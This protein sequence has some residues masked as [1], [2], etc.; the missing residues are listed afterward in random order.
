VDNVDKIC[1]EIGGRLRTA[2]VEK[3]M[4]QADVA[5]A[6]NIA[7]SQYGKVETGKVIPSLKTLIKAAEVLGTNLNKLVYGSDNFTGV[8]I[9]LKD[10]NLIE[11]VN[12]I[13][14]LS[15]EDRSLAIQLLDLIA[16]KKTLKDITD[17]L[18]KDYRG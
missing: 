11:R 18:H 12:I 1:N 7:Q 5:S 13:S 17:N 3:G 6:M 16:A 4:T 15:E 14:Q 9:N 8:E 10:K 2:R